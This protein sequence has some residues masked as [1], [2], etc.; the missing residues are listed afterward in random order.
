MQPLFA[1]ARLTLKAA[2]RYRLVVVLLALLM[3]AVIVLPS[4]IKHDGSAQGFTQILI[5][6]T[7]GSII[8]L[9]GF[10]TL[11]LACGSLAREVEDFSMQLVCTKP[12]ARWQIWLGKWLGIMTLNAGLLTI[13]G[14]M[15]YVLLQSKAGSLKPEQQ[16][17][18]REE[19]LV[20]RKSAREVLPDPEPTVE[21]LFQERIR[22][23]AVAALNDRAFVRKQIREQ[24]VASMQYLR[25]GQARRWKVNLGPDAAERLKD[26]PL[27][28]R[29]KFF[30][31]DYAGSSSTF[32]FGWKIGPPEGHRRQRFANNLAPESFISFE[33]E[34]N[35]IAPDGTLTVDGVNLNERPVLFPLEDGFEVLYHEGGFGLNFIRGLGILFCWLGLLCA[36]GLFAASKLQFNVAA[37]VSF[38]ILLV[39]LSSGTL[40]Q[41][42]EQ[43]GIVGVSS[44]EGIVVEKTILNNASVIVYGTL[45]AVIDQVTGFS[46]VDSLSS[47]RSITWT[48]LFTAV[49]VVIGITGGLFAVAGIW[50]F[51]RRELAAPQ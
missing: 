51:N 5:T 15:V 10:A 18:L 40:K 38:G 26:R 25:P 17:V 16:K 30:T 24:V 47:G 43:G 14:G 8:T 46:P 44:E 29:V 20:A 27:F 41:V 1:V 11:W 9:L 13:S 36:V 2:F 3:G 12:V 37:F 21:R 39:G 6:Y 34:G 48:Q 32:D 49:G 19:V 4:I 22:K 45:R 35:H 31:P 7:L 28:L 50:I 33:V 23:Q 42:V